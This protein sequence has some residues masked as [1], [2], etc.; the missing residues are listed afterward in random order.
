M[1][2]QNRYNAEEGHRSKTGKTFVRV[3]KS[4][5]VYY[6]NPTAYKDK[7]AEERKKLEAEGR[8]LRGEYDSQRVKPLCYDEKHPAYMRYFEK[9]VQIR[10]EYPNW[11]WMTR[12]ECREYYKRIW[13]LM[14]EEDFKEWKWDTRT[15]EERTKDEWWREKDEKDRNY[16]GTG[17]EYRI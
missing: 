13:D 5:R 17:D 6:H 12:E 7:K 3:A 11:V 9:K 14:G 16:D 2:N 8:Q 15:M 4:G 10:S 1:S